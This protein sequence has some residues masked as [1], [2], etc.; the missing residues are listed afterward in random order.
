MIY[1]EKIDTT[2]PSDPEA[3]NCE[4]IVTQK[5][6][7]GNVIGADHKQQTFPYQDATYLEQVPELAQYYTIEG[8]KASYIMINET[9]YELGAICLVKDIPQD[10]VI[11]FEKIETVKPCQ[12]ADYTFTFINERTDSEIHEELSVHVEDIENS[13]D[14]YVTDLFAEVRLELENEGYKFEGIRNAYNPEEYAQVSSKI[15]PGGPYAYIVCFTD[16]DSVEPADYVFTFINEATGEEIREELPVHVADVNTSADKY[17]LDLVADARLKLE[18]NGWVYEG[19][20]NAYNPDEYAQND[21]LIVPGGPY[22]YIVC[23]SLPEGYED[24]NIRFEFVN[25]AGETIL[26]AVNYAT[27]C[28][29]SVIGP[30]VADVVADET[31]QLA[32]SNYVFD[33]FAWVYADGTETELNDPVVVPDYHNTTIKVYYA[34]PAHY[35]F[36]F[37]NDKTGEAIRVDTLDVKIDDIRTNVD[38]Y[39]LDLVAGERRTLEEAGWTYVGIRNAYNP[40]EYA[41]NDS[42]IVPGGPYEYLV[43]FTEADTTP[44]EPDNPG[45]ED[46]S[47]PGDSDS[48]NNGSGSS[49]SS[50]SGSSDDA[51]KSSTPADNSAKILP[52]TGYGESTVS[53]V[54]ITAV[55]LAAAAGAAAYLFAV[56]RRMH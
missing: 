17:V 52:K 11:Y 47:N 16:D 13:A 49:G 26:P 24:V 5:D 12:S 35:R 22:R 41:Q 32:K 54:G 46:P 15:V 44:E 9:K 10:L 33:H 1:F 28:T 56:R 53:V 30:K 40:D 21:S 27:T 45:T 36:T 38:K 7:E 43:C 55:V 14:K 34:Q 29:D 31:A 4:Y 6:L 42:L 19:I 20:R 8:Y 50:S 2:E 23:F 51:S 3:E 48:G 39:V 37:V 18:N 25:M